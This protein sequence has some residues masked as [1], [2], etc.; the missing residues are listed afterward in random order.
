MHAFVM[1]M[2]SNGVFSLWTCSGPRLAM[3]F[4]ALEQSD[5]LTVCAIIPVP[6]TKLR[7]KRGQGREK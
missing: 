3:G 1:G 4:A 5:L 6:E 2:A 7:E